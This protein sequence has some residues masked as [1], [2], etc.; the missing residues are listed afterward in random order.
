MN[1]GFFF[2]CN[3]IDDLDLKFP[4]MLYCMFQTIY[5]K[6]YATYYF[7]KMKTQLKAADSHFGNGNINI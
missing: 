4:I 5:L 3:L 6:C 7:L 1:S 2:K